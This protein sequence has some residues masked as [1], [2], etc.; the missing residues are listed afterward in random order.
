M[1]ENL[2]INRENPLAADIVSRL[3]RISR[4]ELDGLKFTRKKKEVT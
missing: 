1:A 2:Q 4:K 3:G